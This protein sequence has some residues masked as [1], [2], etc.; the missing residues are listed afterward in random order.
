M[1]FLRSVVFDMRHGKWRK[2]RCV[3]RNGF[4]RNGEKYRISTYKLAEMDAYKFSTC[5]M[6][7]ASN[8]IQ[9]THYVDALLMRKN[10]TP[11]L[12]VWAFIKRTL[13]ERNYLLR[14]PQKSF[15]QTR[16]EWGREWGRG[17]RCGGE[18]VVDC[19][20]CVGVNFY[21]NSRWQSAS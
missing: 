21:W 20:I 15:H 18:I 16:R 6:A 5:P 17:W 11:Q 10:I 2:I 13:F 1:Y 14:C 3:C 8:Y 4:I 12:T 19:N 9:G 7:T